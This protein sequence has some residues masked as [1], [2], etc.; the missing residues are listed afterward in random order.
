MAV[1]EWVESKFPNDLNT[2]SDLNS[3]IE[4]YKELQEIFQN[5]VLG[6]TQMSDLRKQLVLYR[7]K[8]PTLKSTASKRRP[9]VDKYMSAKKSSIKSKSTP[10]H[11][12]SS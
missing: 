6:T 7:L 9:I 8:E 12:S 11:P 3:M 4:V 10:K 1:L 2:I 5:K